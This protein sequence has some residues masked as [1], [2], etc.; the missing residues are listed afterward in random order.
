MVATIRSLTGRDPKAWFGDSADP[1]R[2]V[3][4]SLAEEAARVVRTRVVNPR[5]IEAMQRHGYKG[6]F[7]MAATVDYLFGYDA[8]AH[9]VDDWMYERVTDA[10]T[11][12]TRTCGSSSSESNPWAL[13]SIAERLLEADE[14]GH[15]ERRAPSRSATLRDAVLEAEGWEEARRR[16]QPAACRSRPSSARTTPSWPCCSPRSSPGSA[17]C[18]C[19]ARRGRRRRPWPGPGRAAARRR[20]RSSSSRWAPPRTGCSARS[21]WPQLLT[22]GTHAVPPRPAR[23]GATAACSTSTRSTC[24]PTTSSTRCSTWPCRAS[25]ASS[26]TGVSH[27]H[28]ARFVLVGSMNPEEGELRPQLARPLRAG[29]RRAAPPTCRRP[30]RSGAAASSGRTP[31]TAV[32]EARRLT[33]D[34]AP[35]WRRGAVGRATSRRRRGRARLPGG[36][37]GRRGGAA[38]RPHARAAPPRARWPAG[39][40]GRRPD[41]DLRRVAPAR[42]GPSPPP[43]SLRRAGDQP[44]ELDEALESASRPDPPPANGRQRCATRAARGTSRPPTAAAR[45]TRRGASKRPPPPVRFGRAEAPRGRFVREAPFGAT[46]EATVDPRG[47]AVALATRRAAT[48]D[49]TAPLTSDDLPPASTSAGRRAR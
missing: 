41:D 6:A 47:T 21:T 42:A 1:T 25:T 29:R 46:P 43:A 16:V 11:S 5:W 15:V 28:P 37:R 19:G 40:D 12:P 8:T 22:A 49:A 30:G 38:G 3:V 14:R 7:E 35:R 48:G 13:A 27:T 39:R 34:E 26:A 4:R 33:E 20:A 24:W 31:A 44:E 36:P 9:V 23:R 18:C 10:P 17:A 32:D 45:S 2:P